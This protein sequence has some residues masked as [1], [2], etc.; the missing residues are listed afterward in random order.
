MS[1]GLRLPLSEVPAATYRLQLNKE[2]GFNAAFDQLDYLASLGISHLYLSPILKAKPGSVHGY[3]VVDH[4]VLN[5]ELGT[6]DDFRRLAQQALSRGIRIIADIVPNHMCVTD[7]SNVAWWDV[8]EN[9]PS[10]QYSAYFDIDWN[11]PKTDLKDKLLLPVLGDQFGRVL[12]SG[13]MGV[14]LENGTFS[15]CVYDKRFPLAPRSWRLLLEPAATRLRAELGEDNTDVMELESIVTAIQHLPLRTETD[16]E[17]LRERY[18]EK[19][20]VRRR[21]DAL[22]AANDAVRLAVE[23]EVT[24]I[25]G[26]PGDPQSYDRL[27]ELLQDQAYRL[28][29]WRVAAD[30]INYRR[31]FDMNELAA[32]RVEDPSV[33]A[34]VHEVLLRLVGEG[35]IHGFRV[36]HPD[37]LYDPAG[38]F[39]QL[40][41]A[42]RE[43]RPDRSDT[44]FYVVAEKIL[45]PAEEL[46]P[47]AIAG[48]TGYGY[49]NLLNG[50]FVDGSRQHAFERLYRNYTG[51]TLPYEDL[52]YQSKRLVLQVAMSSELNVLARRLDRISEAHR[53]SRDFT[54]ENLRFALREIITCFPIYRTY[55]TSETEQPD[56]EDERHI[57]SAVETAKRRNPAVTASVF[58]FIQDLLLLRHPPES[59]PEQRDERRRFALRVQQFTGPVMARGLEDTLFYRYVPLSSLNE[60][61]GE[62]DKFGT[63]LETF[64]EKS[65]VRVRDW[66]D[67]MLATST[68]DTKRGEDVR[69]RINVLS[70]MPQDWSAALH[71]WHS[72]NLGYRARAGQIMAPSHHD[73]Y[74]LYQTLIG[75]WPLGSQE[76][77]YGER[78]RAYMIKAIREAKFHSS[79]IRPNEAYEQA[80]MNFIDRI[81]A[82]TGF[83]ADFAKFHEPI[84]RAGMLNSVAQTLIK[85][86]SPGVPDFYQGT[87]TWEFTLVDPDNRRPVDYGR[88]ADL[89]AQVDAAEW[90]DLMANWRDGR[91]KMFVT[92]KMLRLRRDNH[93]LFARG[94]YVPLRATGPGRGHIIAFARTMGPKAV[95]AVTGR[96]F[97]GE[98]NWRQTELLLPKALGGGWRDMFSGREL[99]IRGRR[100]AVDALFQDA[101]IVLL[102]RAAVRA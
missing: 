72:M 91:V 65:D 99:T 11:P 36:D 66:P 48:T 26:V 77:N 39:E 82:D 12:E 83:C 17:R 63:S 20:V 56:P 19:E 4:R 34:Q 51:V 58:D 57:R 87:E 75:T 95:M 22:L 92:A 47:W 18:R 84:A 33:F 98:P 80:T 23:A 89:L 52:F 32:I 55:L 5:P 8:L 94:A 71:R 29:Y 31:F 9:G 68:H 49:M 28:S 25:N 78:I 44:P 38:Y 93:E 60:V 90:P 21:L 14:R 53:Y 35:L 3:D 37:G 76:P 46:R 70:E 40:Q 16:P 30:E 10:S 64:H 61:G 27:E 88:R 97:A 81:L 85:I 41:R 15:L 54:L 100:I 1:H 69:A 79:W 2:F 24:R 50:L 67:A 13:Q 6:E 102:E 59:T 43:V 101:P 62:P 96:F 74:L 7:P 73:E 45:V 42:V 86:A